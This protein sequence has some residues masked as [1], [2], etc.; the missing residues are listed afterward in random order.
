[1]CALICVCAECQMS[2]DRS[3]VYFHKGL[4]YFLNI[5]LKQNFNTCI[6]QSGI[7]PAHCGV[8]STVYMLLQPA[9]PLSPRKLAAGPLGLFT[10]LFPGQF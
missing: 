7:A 8:A 5:S 6:D 1:M 9:G 2:S 3:Q 4:V 10:F